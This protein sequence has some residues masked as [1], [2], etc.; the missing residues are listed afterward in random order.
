MRMGLHKVHFHV[1][2]VLYIIIRV[3]VLLWNGHLVIQSLFFLFLSLSII[4]ISTFFIFISTFLPSF[5]AFSLFPNLQF[6]LFHTFTL[7]LHIRSIWWWCM[8]LW[9]RVILQINNLRI[10]NFIIK[11]L[12]LNL[13]GWDRRNLK[14]K[15]R[16]K[17]EVLKNPKALMEWK[18]DII[19]R[20]STCQ[21]MWTAPNALTSGAHETIWV[22]LIQW[23]WNTGYGY[24][25]TLHSNG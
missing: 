21:K 13:I 12:D 2:S 20:P 16:Q 18:T 23:T 6:E 15:R 7:R 4:F 22:K 3:F 10:K 17:N 14:C 9:R 5:L 1:S 19:G 11:F 8:Q 25:C 24:W